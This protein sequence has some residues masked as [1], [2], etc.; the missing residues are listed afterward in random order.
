MAA[1]ISANGWTIAS[2]GL[3]ALFLLLQA[4]VAYGFTLAV[5]GWCLLRRG[6][7][8]IRINQTLPPGEVP[9][10]LPATAIIIPI[11]NEDVG[12]VFQ[13]LRVMYESLRSTGR[14]D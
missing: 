13:G 8:P 11:F 14:S 4:P 12:R 5:T 10:Q 3:F 6:G 9:A 1:R 2:V 7:D